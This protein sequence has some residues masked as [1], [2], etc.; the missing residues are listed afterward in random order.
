[1]GELLLKEAVYRI[2]PTTKK[3]EKVTDEIFKPNGL[4]FSPDYKKLYIA[5]TG[6]SHYPKAPRNIK[7][8]DVADSKSLKGGK[9]FCSMGGGLADG[10]RADVNGNIYVAAG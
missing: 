7:V 3:I 1:M 10:I 8:W 4:C 2:D 5:D 9:E 6:A